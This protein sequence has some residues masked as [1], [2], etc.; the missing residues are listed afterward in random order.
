MA[1]IEPVRPALGTIEPSGI[2]PQVLARIE[3]AASLPS[4][5]PWW[6]RWPSSR[7]QLLARI[8]QTASPDREVEPV[9]IEPRQLP[10]PPVRIEPV[11][12][13]GGGADAIFPARSKRRPERWGRVPH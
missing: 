10:T 9:A 11:R 3:R 1:D 4:S 13:R 5:S 12:G 8:E 7:A 2:A 6:W